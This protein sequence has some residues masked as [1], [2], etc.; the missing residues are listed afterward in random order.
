MKNATFCARRAALHVLQRIAQG[1]KSQAALDVVLR[2]YS[3]GSREAGLCTQLVYGYLRARI[4][5]EAVLAAVLPRPAALPKRVYL[6]LTLAVY[7]LLFLDRVPHHATVFWTVQ[8]VRAKAGDRLARLANA[9]LRAVIRLGKAP[10]SS[11]FY[12]HNPAQNA[13][14]PLPALAQFWAVPL[15]IA[16]LWE[17]SY[18]LDAALMLMRRSFAHPVIALRL[19]PRH[20]H[21]A[22]AREAMLAAGAH[23]VGLHGLAFVDVPAPQTVLGQSMLHWHSEG[24]FSWQSA[25]SQCAVQSVPHWLGPVWDACAGQGGK[26]LALLEAGHD[27][28]VCSDIHWP[29]LSLLRAQALRLGLP[30]PACVQASVLTA[31]IVAW[32][33][34]IVLDVP[35]SGLGTLARRPEIRD[36]LRPDALAGCVLLQAKMLDAAFQRLA[37]GGQIVY[38]TCTLNPA[39]NEEQVRLFCMRQQGATCVYQWQTPHEHPWLEGMFVALI[40]KG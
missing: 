3:L 37:V 30:M 26:A 24:V 28:R 31:P 15:W 16:R 20:R 34:T 36:R 2:E 32:R 9:A 25:G 39:E 10:H 11:D 40:L 38:M 7:A 22:H 1:Q 19:N 14:D 17:S 18:G 12:V 4:R 29:R 27:V 35:C 21:Y 33:G 5:L 8:A 23:A 6:L 13:I